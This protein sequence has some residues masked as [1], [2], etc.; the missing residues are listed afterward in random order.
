M[1]A[2]PPEQRS[3]LDI[4]LDHTV[5]GEHNAVVFRIHDND[6]AELAEEEEP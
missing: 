4:V 3:L 6:F 1:S 2:H 5:A